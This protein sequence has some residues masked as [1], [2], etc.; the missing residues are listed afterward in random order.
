MKTRSL[1]WPFVMVATGVIWILVNLG[2]VPSDNLWALYYGFPYLL[3]A[4]GVGLILRSRWQ[5]AGMI[6]SA[7]VVVAMTLAIVFA[8]PLGWNTPANWNLVWTNYSFNGLGAVPGSGVAQTE[9]REL[10]D[11]TAVSVDY[12]VD[13]VIQQ[14]D[15]QSVTVE[16]DDNLLPQ[17]RTRV[18]GGVLYVE[19]SE[20]IHSK[21]VNPTMTVR[22][23]I[24]VKEL[25][26]VNFP[27]VGNVRI[28]NFQTDSLKITVDGAGKLILDHVT[29]GSLDIS[30]DG[31]GDIEADG[32]ADSI[33]VEIGGVGN[34]QGANMSASNADV[35]ITGA[36]NATIWAVEEL[37]VNIDGVGS[38]SYY[39]SPQVH[40]SV[41][42]LGTVRRLG[43]K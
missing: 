8:A 4:L 5:I 6:V 36:G 38:V 24:T 28:E 26:E 35:T 9:T 42:G 15:T 14:G 41:D 16:A 30:L 39:G 29:V 10:P 23:N 7:L 33:T 19:N 27:M 1:F 13:I 40:E 17:L 3:L 37:T 21:R 25:R 32:T 43:D 12:P 11:F 31:A 22:I 2:V 18:S 20:S 34:Y